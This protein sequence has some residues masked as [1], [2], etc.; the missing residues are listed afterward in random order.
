MLVRTSAKEEREEVTHTI[1]RMRPRILGA[2]KVA[3]RKLVKKDGLHVCSMAAF[4]VA[5]YSSPSATLQE[6]YA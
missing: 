1:E 4:Q 3:R 6:G 2:A 5:T